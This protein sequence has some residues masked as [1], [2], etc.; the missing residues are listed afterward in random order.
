MGVYKQAKS[1][2]W[3]YKFDWNAKTIR[4]STKQ[5]NKRIAEQMEAARRT[6]LAKGEVG[7]R[8]RKPVLTLK[9]FSENVF[10]PFVRSTFAAKIKT[11][12]Y[13]ENGVQNLLAFD[14]LANERLNTITTDRISEYAT[15]RQAAAGKNGQL[16]QVASL[17]R[18]LQVLRRMFHLAEEWGQVEK[19]LPKVKMLSGEKHR[20]RVLSA[21]EEACYFQAASSEA[22]TEHSDPG[23]L[24]D[25]ATIL[26]D[27]GLRPEEC[28][29]LRT[30]SVAEGNIDVLFGKTGNARRR[31][32]MTP[33]VRA[34]VDMRLTTA[35]RNGWLF[36]AL[37]ASG[38]IEPSSLKKQHLKALAESNKAVSAPDSEGHGV[39][40][41]ELYTLRHTCLTRWAPHM[42]P[43]TLAYLAGHRDM[44]ITKRYVHPQEHTILNAMEKAREVTTRH[45]SR[46]TVQ[47]EESEGVLSASAIN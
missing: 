45:T 34:V 9:E 14:R 29:R 5:T 16:L 12:Q 32:P 41:F 13:Y 42:D 15:K 1:K 8:D 31:I 46:H 36:P 6:A 47:I 3:W 44:N 7:I 20:E 35:P 27:C 2:Y 17:N 26:I 19:A 43:W 25:V 18:E 30:E 22:M 28:F 23:L 11:R 39:E 24:R 40:P 4:E 37:T 38:H 21:D 10:L 33:R